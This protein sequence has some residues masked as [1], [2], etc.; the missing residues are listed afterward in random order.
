[1]K[2]LQSRSK[3]QKHTI[4]IYYDIQ[5]TFQT[6][7]HEKYLQN[8]KSMIQQKK[9]EQFSTF[10]NE[11]AKPSSFGRPN[12]EHLC[13]FYTTIKSVLCSFFYQNHQSF[14]SNSHRSNSTYSIL[15]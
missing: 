12:K 7:C 4:P 3:N 10:K 11:P 15:F 2:S 1:M 6:K 14:P 9:R 8:T 5:I 13:K